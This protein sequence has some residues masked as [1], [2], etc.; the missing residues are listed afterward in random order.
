MPNE[1]HPIGFLEYVSKL[2]APAVI[3]GWGFGS[4]IGSASA[5]GLFWLVDF[6]STPRD[7]FILSLYANIPFGMAGAT[8]GIVLSVAYAFW[9]VRLQNPPE[10]KAFIRGFA[11]FLFGSVVLIVISSVW[12]ISR[13]PM[14]LFDPEIGLPILVGIGLVLFGAGW[15]V[16]ST[17]TI[18]EKAL[19]LRSLLAIGTVLMVTG[20]LVPPLFG[21]ILGSR[22]G[23]SDSEPVA[24][25][26][27]PEARGRRL[28][29]VGWDGATWKILDRLL[30]DGK[31]KN[32]AGL[33]EHGER[34][35]LWAEP[36]EIQPFRDSASG[37]A[38]SPA[39][40]ET[41][42]TGKPPRQHG[43][44]DFR[45]TVIPGVQQ[46]IPFRVPE[47]P[48]GTSIQTTSQ[49]SRATRMWRILESVGL[50]TAVIGWYS[51]WPVPDSASGILISD[52]ALF[53]QSNAITPEGVVD[54]ER[55][56]DRAF[57]E[58]ERQLLKG[59]RVPGI[60]PGD[61]LERELLKT[62]YKAY[63]R[64]IAK[65][66]AAEQILRDFEPDFTAVY[67]NLIDISQHKLW[68]YYEPEAFGE[69][70]S[71]GDKDLDRLIP[72]SYQLADELLGRL[73]DAAGEDT[74]VIILSDHG[75]GPWVLGGLRSAVGLAIQRTYHP[76]YSGN[77]RMDGILVM[78]GPQFR[79]GKK[80]GDTDHLDLVPT[81]LNFF[82]LP[83]ADDMPGQALPFGFDGTSKLTVRRV[84]TYDYLRILDV[85]HP[86]EE[87]E[88]DDEIQRMLKSL[89]YIQ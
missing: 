25:E 33:L 7:F 64:D 52:L 44:W 62:Y 9:E 18:P 24:V 61:W 77:H 13:R 79:S 46:V 27:Q 72:L 71:A 10:E 53:G 4:L 75:S 39:L 63:A 16:R 76:D 58:T 23:I 60:P 87:T 31:M 81:V 54:F 37:G 20:I 65:A 73:V 29:I 34:S 50:S 83:I 85:V 74:S 32:L 11:A 45:C 68:R 42:A 89:G 41:L 38:R 69:D 84:P 30:A 19:S 51:T 36:Q 2:L 6:S 70:V 47:F 35:V 28:L 17:S 59:G 5:C 12:A 78:S 40:W 22:Q 82:G 57:V 88:V 67:L 26:Q 14:S 56:L 8:L 86:Q 55:I 66:E 21:F 48:I 1:R 80:I 43:I 49:M 3:L 15:A